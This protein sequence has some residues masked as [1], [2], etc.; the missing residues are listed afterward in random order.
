MKLFLFDQVRLHVASANRSLSNR[1][2]LYLRC[3]LTV[4]Y[5]P[6]FKLVRLSVMAMRRVL[7]QSMSSVPTPSRLIRIAVVLNV[8]TSCAKRR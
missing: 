6:R 4:L 3:I 1:P 5:Y 7:K 2:M 8:L